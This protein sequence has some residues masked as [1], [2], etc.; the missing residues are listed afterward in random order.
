MDDENY[1]QVFY[2]F[3]AN[4]YSFNGPGFMYVLSNNLTASQIMYTV[5]P[6]VKYLSSLIP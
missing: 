6:A 3:K 2:Y 1:G 5:A 4:A